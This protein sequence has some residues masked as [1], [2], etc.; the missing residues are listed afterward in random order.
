[1]LTI[2]ILNY[3][4]NNQV[5]LNDNLKMSVVE[6]SEIIKNNYDLSVN[7]Y[8]KKEVNNVIYRN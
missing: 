1:M 7:L 2:E 8:I 3:K 5:K 6:K 4:H